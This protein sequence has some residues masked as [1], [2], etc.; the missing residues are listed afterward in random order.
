MANST[1]RISPSSHLLKATVPDQISA[2]SQRVFD[3]AVAKAYNGK[4]KII[5]FEVFAGEKANEV[6][7]PNTWL[8][9]DTL[10]AIK[11]HIVAIKG[12]L[13]TPIGGGIRSINVSLRQ[14]LD[15]MS[16]SGLYNILPECHRQ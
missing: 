3:A 9:D 14:R 15:F 11:E 12:P 10:I 16:V 4:K 5:W 13:T 1:F 7:G 8:H 6:Y 2:R